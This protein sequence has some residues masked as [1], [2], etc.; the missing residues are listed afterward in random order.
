MEEQDQVAVFPYMSSGTYPT[1]TQRQAASALTNFLSLP[2]EDNVVEPEP[3]MIQ[4]KGRRRP[5]QRAQAPAPKD[6]SRMRV[7]DC[8]LTI[9]AGGGTGAD[10]PGG[11]I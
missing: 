8:K 1:Q 7:A 3:P 11:G 9:S 5:G 6:K 10:S 4:Q 2:S